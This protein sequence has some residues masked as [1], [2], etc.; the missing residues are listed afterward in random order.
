VRDLLVASIIFGS[1]PIIFFRPY[2]GIIV[3]T[4][5]S[6]MSPHRLTWGFAHDFPFANRRSDHHSR[7][8]PID[9][10]KESSDHAGNRAAGGFRIVDAAH[11]APRARADRSVDAWDKVSK[12]Q[13]VILLTMVLISSRG[14]LE[15]LIWMIV[16]SVGFYGVKGGLFTI[17]NGGKSH[18][19]GPPGSFIEDNNH[20]GLAL[21]MV[22]PLMRYLQLRHNRR[23]VRAGLSAA[24]VLTGIAILGTQSRGAFLGI[25]AM[26]VFMALKSRHRV[27][28][29]AASAVPIPGCSRLCPSRGSSEWNP[30]ATSEPIRLRPDASMPGSLR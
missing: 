16:L 13:L 21:V 29:I 6:L 28:L 30:F 11:N 27:G 17:A 19:L 9:T 22:I 5:I 18:V 23:W 20:L 2:V 4:W 14:K 1:L 10:T 7:N 15:L 12:I 26:L 8:R 24:M 3:W 25:I